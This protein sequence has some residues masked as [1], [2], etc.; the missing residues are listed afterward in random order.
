MIAR[1]EVSM[2]SVRVAVVQAGSV[3]FDTPR[4]LDRLSALSAEAAAGGA[5]LVVFPEAFV[6]GYPKGLGFGARMGSRTPEGRE[7]FRRYFDA[8][9]EVPGPA[10]ELIG[11]LARDHALC[12][13]VGAVERAGSTLYCTALFF[14]PDGSLLGRHR[15]L[16]PT[17]IE[18]LVWGQ[19]D[20]STLP[21]ID[22]PVG[23]VGAVICWENYMPL[24]RTAMY[25]KGVE[26]YCAVTV[27]DRDTWLPTMRH[28]A[29][30]GRCYVL[31]ACQ[32]LTRNDCPADYVSGY[33]DD[34]A[35]VLIRGGSCVVGPLGQVLAG[36]VFGEEAVLT[37]DLDTAEIP[38]ARFDFDPVG[39]Y[40]RPDVFRLSVNEAPAP[41]VDFGGWGG[42]ALPT[43][44]SA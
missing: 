39:H 28:V 33:G 8:A 21:V 6:G 20:G 15:K 43:A 27:D 5:K 17:A 19:G 35:A 3:L 2:P 4:T 40:A 42:S 32:Y 36:P 11:N 7:E 23:R 12:L 31:S 10:T 18:R 25:A 34:P 29:L 13:V 41:A 37:A 1:R 9:V 24:L 38:R 16:M 14:G 26:V 44:G 22:T 30:E